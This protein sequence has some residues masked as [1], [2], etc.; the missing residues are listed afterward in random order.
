MYFHQTTERLLLWP[1]ALI[2]IFRCVIPHLK[3]Q[4]SRVWI[5]LLLLQLLLIVWAQLLTVVS[6][7]LLLGE[8]RTWSLCYVQ[9][10]NSDVQDPWTLADHTWC[11][12]PHQKHP[13]GGL[14]RAAVRD[15]PVSVAGCITWCC[16]CHAWGVYMCWIAH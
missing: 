15:P 5:V 14:P 10:L 16:C 4:C 7:K 9:W 8:Y 13:P 2:K 6:A 1:A 12:G 3:D 11:Q